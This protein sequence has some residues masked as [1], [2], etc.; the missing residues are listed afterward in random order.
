MAPHTLQEFYNSFWYDNSNLSLKSKGHSRYALKAA[1]LKNTLQS[2]QKVGSFAS[3]FQHW[4][5]QVI[6][7]LGILQCVLLNGFFTVISSFHN[8][9]FVAWCRFIF[10]FSCIMDTRI[11]FVDLHHWCTCPQPSSSQNIFT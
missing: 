11:L 4:L 5:I 8:V 7:L 6:K 10:P 2:R 1:W 9:I 3:V